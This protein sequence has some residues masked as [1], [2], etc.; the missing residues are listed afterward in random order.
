MSPRAMSR[1]DASTLSGWVADAR[2]AALEAY[3]DFGEDDLAVPYLEISTTTSTT[4]TAPRHR[5]SSPPDSCFSKP[6]GVAQLPDA[7]REKA[8]SHLMN[9]DLP[10]LTSISEGG[11]NV[12]VEVLACGVPVLS[13]RI[14]GAIGTLGAD[15]Q[16]YFEVGDAAGLASLLRRWETEP[17]FCAELR[18]RCATLGPL[19]DPRL[20]WE[21]WRALLQEIVPA[22]EV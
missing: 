14:E 15:Y 11:A 9:A 3:A 7:A 17:A 19:T 22:G 20:E 6:L 13:S 2:K 8:R 18:A 16:G 5:S 21:V 12:I 10:L 4:T 1:V